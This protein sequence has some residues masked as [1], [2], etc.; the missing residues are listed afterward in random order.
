MKKSKGLTLPGHEKSKGEVGDFHIFADDLMPDAHEDLVKQYA[1]AYKR[2]DKNVNKK[3]EESLIMGFDP[4]DAVIEQPVKSK[5]LV[6]QW[7]KINNACDKAKKPK[8]QH[9]KRIVESNHKNI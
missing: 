5:K 4:R 1:K 6:K 9:F 2:V 7:A 8:K 3:R